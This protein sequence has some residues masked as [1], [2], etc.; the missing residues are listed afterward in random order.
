MN[1]YR[2]VK[3]GVKRA[4]SNGELK[5]LLR[6]TGENFNNPLPARDLKPH[7][8]EELRVACILDEFTE[9]QLGDELRLVPIHP[10]RWFEPFVEC[11]DLLLV[12]SFWKGSGGSWGSV[13]FEYNSKERELLRRIV[14]LCKENG[15]PTAFWNKEDPAH[16]DE[17][18]E[19]ALEFDHIFTTDLNCV[20][21][22]RERGKEAKVLPFAAQTSLFNPVEIT[23]ERLD[24][25][26]FAGSWITFYPERNAFFERLA[27]VLGKDLDVFDRNF[28]TTDPRYSFPKKYRGIIKG[29]LEG[30]EILRAYK[31]YRFGLNI[32]SVTDSPT[33]LARR[34]FELMAC[35]TPVLSNY[36]EA[37]RNLFDDQVIH[38]NDESV[39]KRRFDELRSDEASYRVLR[40]RALR[41]VMLHH[42]ILDRVNVLL[43]ECVDHPN[44]KKTRKVICLCRDR[45][46]L[47]RLSP[48]INRQAYDDLELV[49]IE[50]KDTGALWNRA[51]GE[52]ALVIRMD[53][54]DFHGEHFILDMALAFFY[55][56]AEMVT[57]L[58]HYEGDVL[59]DDGHQ[60]RW[61]DEVQPRALMIDPSKVGRTEA[62]WLWEGEASQTRR[63]CLC[64]DEFNFALGTRELKGH[65]GIDF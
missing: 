18:I 17:F 35:N 59:R 33:M 29:R 7:R 30:Q 10:D 1:P 64:L 19:M 14:R 23:R 24:R 47:N 21:K 38:S 16:F 58:S 2:R 48:V 31:G 54:S 20:P 61:V 22:Y 11:V 45:V 25:V 15:I 46:E 53:G 56:D 63:K 4:L 34:V 13:A 6:R 43:N 42:T 65:D 55:S 52:R 27:G 49:V 41:E 40:Q 3:R 57:K 9:Q 37:I 60:F 36:S 32:N 26:S 8:K 62:E 5:I 12:E 50:R 51:I 44:D 39:L 28:G